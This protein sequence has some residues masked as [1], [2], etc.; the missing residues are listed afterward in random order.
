VFVH[1][2]VSEYIPELAITSIRLNFLLLLHLV[3]KLLAG[4]CFYL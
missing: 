4:L 3:L 1:V 2:F